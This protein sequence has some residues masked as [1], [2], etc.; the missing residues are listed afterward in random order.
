MILHI[1]KILF[2]IFHFLDSRVLYGGS[3]NAK[4]AEGFLREP[5]I[6]GALV[7]GASLK[8]D[9]FAKILKAAAKYGKV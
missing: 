7:G 4:N 5:E 2:S 1:K 3:V 8:S 6:G 9:E